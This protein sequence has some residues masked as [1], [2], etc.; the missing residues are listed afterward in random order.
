M[1]QSFVVRELP[2]SH[3]LPTGSGVNTHAP[4]EPTE[5]LVAGLPS[6][7]TRGVPAHRNGATIGSIPSV[8]GRSCR[9]ARLD[10]QPD[11][12]QRAATI[13]ATSGCGTSESN[14]ARTCANDDRAASMA[15]SMSASVIAAHRNM[16]CQGC[17]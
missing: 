9:P 15:R 5:S 11:D 4:L 17:M 14:D 8:P 12:C 10:D 1:I 13:A 7:Q 3:G 2:S 16:L 6:L